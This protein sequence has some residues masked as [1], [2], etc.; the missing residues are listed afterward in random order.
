M[1]RK[2]PA[3]VRR[4]GLDLS[5]ETFDVED[6]R[7]RL[8]PRSPSSLKDKLG[9]GGNA[10]VEKMRAEMSR[11]EEVMFNPLADTT[12]LA[13][14]VLA[15]YSPRAADRAIDRNKIVVNGVVAGSE[16][17]VTRLISQFAE[18][19][20]CK[21]REH[22]D[23][24][25]GDISWALVTMVETSGADTVLRTFGN[26]HTSKLWRFDQ[27][28]PVTVE[29]FT[30]EKMNASRDKTQDNNYG[31]DTPDDDLVS[32]TYAFQT[33]DTDGRE[34]IDASEFSLMLA[35]MGCDVSIEEIESL[36]A[37]AKSGFAE[38]VRIKD[39]STLARCKEVWKPVDTY[40]SGYLG[41]KK[42][43]VVITSLRRQGLWKNLNPPP[44]VDGQIKLEEFC[45]WYIAQEG[46]SAEFG[47]PPT[48]GR[49]PGTATGGLSGLGQRRA[50]KVKTVQRVVK[51]IALTPFEVLKTSGEEIAAEPGLER[52]EHKAR[53]MMRSSGHL[54]FA[55]FVFLVRAGLLQ[56]YLSGPW[57][58]RVVTMRKLREAFD[59]ADCDRNNQLK[60]SEL[61][62]VVRAMNA[63]ITDLK[64]ESIRQVWAILNPGYQPGVHAGGSDSI[65]FS[66][67]VAGM[68]KVRDDP[69]L[70]MVVPIHVPNR[71]AP[72]SL[73]ID[74]PINEVEHKLITKKMNVLERYGIRVLE[75]VAKDVGEKSADEVEKDPYD[76]GII[77]DNVTKACKGKLHFLT[78]E[79]RQKM[80]TLH[81]TCVTRAFLIGVVWSIVPGLF[82]NFFFYFFETDG[83]VNAHWTCP[84]TN[85]DMFTPSVMVAPYNDLGLQV[86]PF[87]TCSLLPVFSVDEGSMATGEL[88]VET[89]T[90]RQ[91]SCVDAADSWRWCDIEPALQSQCTPLPAT[92]FDDVRFL[93]FNILNLTAIVGCVVCELWLLMYTAVQ[94][95]VLVSHALDMQLTPLNEDRARVAKMLV[96]AAFE[97]PEKQKVMGVD[98]EADEDEHALHNLLAAAWYKGKTFIT[99]HFL[100]LI[101]KRVIPYQFLVFS[102]PYLA[103]GVATAFWDAMCCHH[104]MKL[105]E[106]RAVGVTTAI[107]VFNDILDKFCPSFERE[108]TSLTQ[109]ARIQ[110]LRAIGIAVVRHG[111]I[112]PTME[113]LLL[114]AI[115]YLD[116]RQSSAVQSRG[117]IDNQEDFIED[118]AQL[119][120]KERRA[121]LCIHMLA[122]VLDG[123]IQSYEAKLWEVLLQRVEALHQLEKKQVEVATRT[124]LRGWIVEQTYELRDAV[125]AIP[126]AEDEWFRAASEDSPEAQVEFEAL[127]GLFS[128]QARE[129]LDT[130]W[131]D[132]LVPRFVCQRFRHNHPGNRHQPSN[133]HKYTRTC[134]AIRRH[135]ALP[136]HLTCGTC[137]LRTVTTSMLIACFDPVENVEMRHDISLWS[138]R[139]NEFTFNAMRVM[140]A[141]I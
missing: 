37:Q 9:H 117:V 105:A 132:G 59:I 87:G 121:V 86:C 5:V 10:R 99:G 34:Y 76:I 20:D 12:K 130:P 100:L 30:E 136:V 81:R 3:P 7:T 112:S 42:L 84:G 89:E 131:N 137:G 104:I 107:E 66:M 96:Q 120:L 49:A 53:R 27:K 122:Y 106:R 115:E 65:S 2:A 28:R 14:D 109:N 74:T 133:S 67:F 22:R 54:V 16:A 24:T 102:R 127:R 63:R 119:T 125:D 108:P 78:D 40:S 79:Q 94:F 23:A 32:L 46:F 1:G 62:L 13:E 134:Y 135:V 29:R 31:N 64:T 73:L 72:L 124:Q 128:L 71:F 116:M 111:S 52:T 43:A 58:E 97:V 68:L 56:Q 15:N 70:G 110:M 19:A 44:M 82:E 25:G 90:T 51:A 98:T 17:S 18:V 75:D 91:E 118:F 50:T 77:E 69:E 41:V 129:T 4:S 61:E 101:L 140:L 36:I 85:H 35:L 6:G 39:S 123:S 126:V 21:V 103:A 113:V 93:S 48:K 138:F 55:E 80:Q 114:H 139:G 8:S 92:P 57:Q 26:K 95:A 141:T 88:I 83:F 11:D 45:T 47:S 38:W 33:V 60:Y